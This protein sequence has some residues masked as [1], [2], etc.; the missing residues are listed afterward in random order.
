M[1]L[2]V[3]ILRRWQMTKPTGKLIY[4]GVRKIASLIRD[5]YRH[6]IDPME[7]C[8]K[9]KLLKDEGVVDIVVKGE[10]GTFRRMANGYTFLPW[11]IIRH[12]PPIIT[13]MCNTENRGKNS[14][15]HLCVTKQEA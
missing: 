10:R 6:Y 3:K 5:E 8:R 15:T 14:D 11:S 7:I 4:I 1:L 2:I 13:H 12:T 9:I